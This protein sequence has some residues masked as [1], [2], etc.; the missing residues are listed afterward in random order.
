MKNKL[1]QKIVP[2]LL[3]FAVIFSLLPEGYGNAASS[4][5]P[6]AIDIPAGTLIIG[7]HIISIAGLNSELLAIALD[8]GKTSQQD[9]IFY[10]SEFA[11]GTWFDISNA[12]SFSDISA[13]GMPVGNSV[14]DSLTLTHWTKE[15]GKTYDLSNNS[16]VDIHKIEN[17]SDFSSL[18]ELAEL[19]TRRDML[20]ESIKSSDDDQADIDN[21]RKSSIERILYAPFN[22]DRLNSIASQMDSLENYINYL[23]NKKAPEDWINTAV[24]IKGRYNIL[25]YIECYNE[26][27]E[28]LND[29]ILYLDT[30]VYDDDGKKVV[31]TELSTAYYSCLDAVNKKI[32]ELETGA[33]SVSAS[34]YMDR[35]RSKYSEAVVQ[36]ASKNNA[37]AFSEADTNLEKYMSLENILAGLKPDIPL[38]LS[39][40]NPLSTTISNA[41]FSLSA[42]GAPS[43]Y[44]NAKSNNETKAVLSSIKDKHISQLDSLVSELQAVIGY[45]NEREAQAAKKEALLSAI[46]SSCL[47]AIQKVPSDDLKEDTVNILKKLINWLNAELALLKQN[48]MDSRLLDKLNELDASIADLTTQY[49]TALDNRQLDKALA[50]KEEI[51][52]LADQKSDIYGNSLSDQSQLLKQKSDLEAQLEKAL[53]SGDSAAAQKA[54]DKLSGVNASLALQSESVDQLTSSNNNSL[55]GLAG[56]LKDLLNGGKYSDALLKLNEISGLASASSTSG[57]TLTSLLTGLLPLVDTRYNAAVESKNSQNANTLKEIKSILKSL[58]GDASKQN[59]AAS[60]KNALLNSLISKTDGLISNSGIAIDSSQGQ[61]VRLVLLDALSGTDE[62]LPIKAQIKKLQDESINSLESSGSKYISHKNLNSG[63]INYI[64]LQELSS[65]TSRR[66]V[67]NA[68]EGTASITRG[69]SAISFKNN[70]KEAVIN[71]KSKSMPA[72]A[73]SKGNIFYVPMAFTA[74]E[75]NCSWT[76]VGSS[77]KLLI[78][79]DSIDKLVKKMLK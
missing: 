53:A 16:I 47:T 33:A 66:Y 48:G 19:K 18:P 46:L 24:K 40:L 3:I 70:N 60:D 67:W 21:S 59:P 54:L 12:S 56:E 22:S 73:F 45:I 23:R 37:A 44:K 79:P 55:T 72:K 25:K 1:S 36:A 69:S 52:D 5:R 38:E 65:I 11:D 75:L 9:K 34:S 61:L 77:S 30:R 68:R 13:E 6:K 57:D 32:A 15:D 10:K 71:K 39:I 8:S 4:V 63:S 78:Y 41:L 35:E 49:L 58:L 26:V 20:I 51:D 29:E 50:L 42:A 7:T 31:S 43:E 76:F 62:F 27:I 64:S 2:L 17:P 14:I 74:E 28:R